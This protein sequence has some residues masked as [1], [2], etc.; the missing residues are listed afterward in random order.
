MQISD[1]R[2]QLSKNPD[3][4]VLIRDEPVTH[5]SI[6]FS[7]TSTTGAYTFRDL[8][9]CNKYYTRLIFTT[10]LNIITRTQTS[11]GITN[12]CFGFSATKNGYKITVTTTPGTNVVLAQERIVNGG[13]Q[14]LVRPLVDDEEGDMYVAVGESNSFN[15]N[16]PTQTGSGR[17]IFDAAFPKFY[18]YHWNDWAGKAGSV[19][20]ASAPGGFAYFVNVLDYTS[21]NRITKTK[22]VLY[23]NDDSRDAGRTRN[24]GRSL[25]DSNHGLG[26]H[27]YAFNTC[28]E[29][30]VAKA[31][32]TLD[33]LNNESRSP[34]NESIPQGSWADQRLMSYVTD[35]TWRSHWRSMVDGALTKQYWFNLFSDYDCV[36]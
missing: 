7:S 20:S 22:K 6:G 16:N 19:Y 17:V 33:Y 11:S 29:G 35:G 13:L 24:N 3:M 30:L 14:C 8:E 18:N 31:G 26:I 34:V 21:E 27:P 36:I 1:L 32:Y 2:V 9:P 15:C 4:S 23:I 10:N 28:V 12:P 25:G 5:A